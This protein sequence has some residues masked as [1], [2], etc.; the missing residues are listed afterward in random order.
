MKRFFAPIAA[1]MFAAALFAV[2]TLAHKGHQDNMTDAE[3]AQMG[4]QAAAEMHED[5]QGLRPADAEVA[6]VETAQTALRTPVRNSNPRAAEAQAMSDQNE[7]SYVMVRPPASGEA[8][9]A[10]KGAENRLTSAGDLLGRLHP[11]ATH[12]PIALLIFAALAELALVFR[13]T[14]GLQTTVRFLVTGGA[15][16]AVLAAVL[17]W[18]AGGWRLSDRSETLGLHR[19]NGTAI[20]VVSLLAWM[21]A[22]RSKKRAGLRVVLGLLAAAL[23]VQGYLGGEMMSGPNHMGIF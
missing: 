15:L 7:S 18:Y 20:A 12:F 13:P 4:S 8:A 10:A 16:S 23:V 19:W 6:D 9:L 5:M 21:M 1:I 22:A 2:P 3:M 17:G 14:I 11:V